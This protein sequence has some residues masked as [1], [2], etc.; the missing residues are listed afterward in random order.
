MPQH[1]SEIRTPAD[2]R[3]RRA[4]GAKLRD[5][6]VGRPRP[7]TPLPRRPMIDP[8]PGRV[9]ICCSGG[10]IRSAAYNLGALQV[11]RDHGVFGRDPTS[12]TQ[13][14]DVIVS[15]VSGGSYIAASFATVAS[16]S[17]P[18]TLKAG[19]EGGG[20]RRIFDPSSPE[21]VHLRNRSS[22]MAPGLGGTL[23]L[24][25]RVLAGMLANF[26]VIGLVVAVAGM[27]LGAL[28]TLLFPA[29]ESPSVKELD[30]A[31]ALW[32]LPLGS[33]A[34]GAAL[35]LPDL[36]KRLRHDRVRRFFEA[37][38]GRLIAFGLALAIVILVIPSIIMGLRGESV[39]WLVDVADAVGPNDAGASGPSQ[40]TG[41]LQALNLGALVT[42]AAGGLRAFVARKRS[43]FALAAGAVA[44]PLA[45]FVP[46]VWVANET[47]VGG[48]TLTDA[49]VLGGLLA[50][51]VIAWIVVDLNQWSLHPYYRRRLSS[52]FF[53]RRT[54]VDEVEECDYEELL[55]LS[56]IDAEGRFPELIVCAAANVSDQ[57][58]TPPGR[59]ATPFTFSHDEIGGP[60]TSY[61]ATD[62]YERQAKA[63]ARDVT[64][65][66]A[67][68]VS[69]A[70]ISPMMGKRS[71]RAMTFLMALTNLRLGVWLPNP[72][73]VA[74]MA[75][76]RKL[77]SWTTTVPSQLG[78]R[79]GTVREAVLKHVDDEGPTASLL[80]DVGPSA[81]QRAKRWATGRRPRP[82]Y[83]FKEMLG[84]TSI[85]DRFLYVTDGGHFD[86]LGLIELLRRGC[87]TIYCL[88][89]GGDSAGTYEA[90]GEA[91]ALARSEL[92]VDIDID[93]S[94][95]KPPGSDQCPSTEHV[96]GSIRYRATPSGEG[97]THADPHESDALVGTIVYCRAA[98]TADAPWDVRAF[99]A[100]DKR[101]PNHTTFDQLFDDEKFEAYRA[102]GAHSACRAVR[103]LRRRVL[104]D[105]IR[106]A[107]VERAQRRTTVRHGELLSAV[108]SELVAMG[109][110]AVELEPA[111]RR[112]VH[113]LLD[114]IATDEAAAMR[115]PLPAIVD[116]G[117]G[118]RDAAR[119]EQL[120]GVWDYWASPQNGRRPRAAVGAVAAMFSAV[121]R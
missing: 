2:V 95:I 61:V 63:A 36:F 46:L 59:W 88:D 1:F 103:T 34:L 104:Q 40:A 109:V 8:Q 76:P 27:A 5:W 56:A 116:A 69:G 31:M 92:G 32:A 114:A 75:D 70:A 65:P 11:L 17:P 80:R 26:A 68:A 83:L 53:T 28:Y 48:F 12:R 7:R 45:V 30:P 57:G 100:K 89:A 29:L 6:L 77:P 85:D 81:W 62:V 10:G 33:V 118:R 64:L 43:Y 93:P 13:R 44:G 23:R 99:Q 112:L 101:F 3:D 42:A 72:Q 110:V 73:H 35:L 20:P 47:A 107:L 98:V 94:P 105:A 38:A 71:I 102:L 66:A 25:L 79:I 91:V 78:N 49:E 21:E 19:G 115:P 97:E 39:G 54:Q 15:A 22:Y 117:V 96:V 74:Q 9:G 108:Q 58:V 119:R 24:L 111:D 106:R 16:E 120:E 55:P 52:A 121:A 41:L 60:L 86:N 14:R 51:V 90:L 82:E 50:A 87:T 113:T 37:W 67:V 18:S 84:L 4:P